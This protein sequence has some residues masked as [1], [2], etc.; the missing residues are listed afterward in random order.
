MTS[1]AQNQ[2]KKPAPSPQELMAV[3]RVTH[4]EEHAE[5]ITDQLMG[6]QLPQVRDIIEGWLNVAADPKEHDIVRGGV[7]SVGV[8]QV[9]AAL[10]FAVQAQREDSRNSALH[11]F[12]E[13]AS[14][15]LEKVEQ[16]L[17]AMVNVMDRLLSIG[18]GEGQA[19]AVIRQ[20]AAATYLVARAQF[21]HAGCQETLEQ[22]KRANKLLAEFPQAHVMHAQNN[23]RSLDA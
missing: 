15:F 2:M 21:A 6:R 5:T 13:R 17:P 4:V 12:S 16:E 8:K 22:S 3:V 23:L 1:F 11:A 9:I 20:E 19:S 7:L 18:E 10:G 14:A